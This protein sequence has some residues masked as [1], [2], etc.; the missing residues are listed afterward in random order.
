MHHGPS[1]SLAATLRALRGET[2]L[3]VIAPALGNWRFARI[4]ALAPDVD[5]VVGA[6]GA[7]AGGL[8]DL[9]TPD[10]CASPALSAAIAS[11]IGT[12]AGNNILKAWADV[13]PVGWGASHTDALIDAVRVGRCSRGAAAALIGPTNDTAALLTCP[14][15]IAHAV[16]RWG[17]ATPDD[18]TAWM[19]HVTPAELNRFLDVLCPANIIAA[20]CLPWLSAEHAARVSKYIYRSVP[21]YA[22]DGY[23]AAPPVAHAGHAGI[24]SSLMRY[25]TRFDLAELTRLAVA[26]RMDAAWTEVVRI[27]HEHPDAA[28]H[29]VAAAPWDDVPGEVQAAI[30]SAADHSDVC[31]ALAFAR[32]ERSDP[33]AMT[34]DTAFAFFAAVTPE[35]WTALPAETQHAWRS[36]II[37]S[38]IAVLA[39]R[40]LGLDPAFLA[41]ADLDADVIAAVRRHAPNEASLRWTLLPVAVR[42]LPIADI[43][44]VVAALP[45]PDPVAFVQIA[46]C[47]RDLPPALRDWI[48]AHPTPQAMAAASTVLRAAARLATDPVADRCAALAALAD[49]SREETDALLAALPDDAHAALRPDSNALAC[50][51]AHPDRR[52]A[53]RQALDAINSLP[54]ATT[55]PALLA[56]GVLASASDLGLRIQ[57]GR[58]LAH[59]LRDHGDC[60]LALVD[61][62]ANTLRKETFPRPRSATCVAAVRTIAAADPLAAYRL[63]HALRD[64]NAA[65]VLD[66]LADSPLEKTL[67]LWRLLPEALQQFVRG[68]CDA[69]LRD[70]AA[71]GRADA[72]AQTLRGWN[73]DDLL[74]LLALR[75]LID[76]DEARRAR[77]AAILAQQPDMAASLL[78]LLRD[79]VRV[80]LE[81]DPCIAVACADLPPPRPSAPVRRRR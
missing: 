22:L 32:G 58:A 61:A 65:V 77:G 3:R 41:C 68:D 26:S 40:S 31:A 48:T 6:L 71:P 8:P 23:A 72:L 7:L 27:L 75:M 15:D 19:N 81:T 18:P 5:P 80:W 50:A 70:V 74:P 34:P 4:P 59:V 76:D 33:P 56:L 16:R 36:E 49:R 11:L 52:D 60:F 64:G 10:E 13:A 38:D 21:G 73:A 28:R 17:Q 20:R 25:T 44:A 78:P 69:L 14:D 9:L 39:V 57:A 46:G 37:F 2:D 62:L 66:A 29:V 12:E 42:D 24:I 1:P 45:L 53:F 35:V 63:A 67:H 43:P 30:L 47:R 51:L 54:P 79:D 55:R